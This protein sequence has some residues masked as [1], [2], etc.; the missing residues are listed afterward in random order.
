MAFLD[1]VAAVILALLI[2]KGL[3]YIIPEKYEIW[4]WSICLLALIVWAAMHGSMVAALILLILLIWWI[5]S[6]LSDK[7]S[8]RGFI[9]S[10]RWDVVWSIALVVVIALVVSL[11]R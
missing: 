3:S 8:V 5:I 6:Y 11:T 9:K 7:K 2:V 10:I 1:I 4:V